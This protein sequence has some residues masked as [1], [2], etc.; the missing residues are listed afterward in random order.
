[1]PLVEHF[2]HH[3]A[4]RLNRRLESITPGAKD[5]LLA[6]DWP[7]NVRELSNIIERAIVLSRSTTLDVSDFAQLQVSAA[8][9]QTLPTPPDAPLREIEERHIRTVLASQDYSISK[10][11]KLLGIHRNT[12]RQKMREYGIE[13]K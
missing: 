9:G 4:R 8:R 3:Y 1:M 13:R 11:A 6:Y 2:L 10:S 5:L 7:G 12:L